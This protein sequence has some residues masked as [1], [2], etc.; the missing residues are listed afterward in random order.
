L[1]GYRIFKNDVRIGEM[2]YNRDGWCPNTF[3]DTNSGSGDIYAITTYN[4]VGMES[5]KIVFIKN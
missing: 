5:P 2:H 4:V 1:L 3:T